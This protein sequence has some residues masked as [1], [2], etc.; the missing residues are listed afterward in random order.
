MLIRF[1]F[2]L[3]L[4]CAAT[5]FAAPPPA[6]KL[7]V[8]ISVDQLRGDY[9]QRFG[10]YFGEGG[11]RRLTAGGL[12]FEDCHYAHALTQTAPGHATILTGAYPMTHGV[13]ANEWLDRGLWEQVNNVEDRTAPL[14]GLTPADATAALV[15]PKAG[16]SPR[17][18]R[19]DTV[20]D[21]L[22]MRYGA[23]AKVFAASNKDRSAILLGGRLADAAYWDENG[24]MVTSRYYREQ[25]PAWVAAFNAERRVHASFGKVWERLLAPAV[26]DAVQ[27]P[28]DAPGEWAESGFTRTF[29]KK[30]TGGR[31]AVGP[32]FFSAFDNSPF[33]TEFLGEFVQRAIVEEKLGRNGATDLLCV[34]FSQVD[35]V[36]HNYGPDSHEVMDSMLRLDRVLAAI[37]DRLDREVGLANCVIVLTADHGVAPLPE[38]V[39]AGRADGPGGRF[40]VAELDAAGR[41][42][43]DA[44]FGAP[45]APEYWF[46]RDNNGFHLR[47]P[48]LAAKKLNRAEVATVLRNAV[49]A[50]PSVAQAYTRDQIEAASPDGPSVL[51]AVRRSYFPERDRDVVMVYQPYL[52]T[53]AN[54]GTSHGTP[55]VYD[56]HVPQVWYGAGVPAGVRKDRVGVEDIAPTLAALLGLSAPAQAQGLRRF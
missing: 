47:L 37:F 31:D 10:P 28:D 2:L 3:L 32:A 45:E 19:A 27:G 30:V 1:R 25:A 38:R 46:T 53:R 7:A 43:L 6:P 17:V 52:Q 11:F 36:G 12:V 42:A 22:K 35:S 55:Y 49:A 5:A 44:A 26:Y 48:V 50:L 54:T 41:K 14:V 18:L 13:I 56:T 21:Q 51:A 29:P 9:L 4:G 20:G 39:N 23:K 15:A 8:V 16:R 24:V 40:K 33:S 34:S